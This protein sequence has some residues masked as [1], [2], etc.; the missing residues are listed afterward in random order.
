MPQKLVKNR[1]GQQDVGADAKIPMVGDGA[2]LNKAFH[3]KKQVGLVVSF[4]E[5][6]DTLHRKRGSLHRFSTVSG[7]YRRHV[8]SFASQRERE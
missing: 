8:V 5:K 3:S 7:W 4:I 1:Y 2:P 6:K